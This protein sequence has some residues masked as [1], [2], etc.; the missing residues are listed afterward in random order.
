MEK[1]H[2][3]WIENWVCFWTSGRR[4]LGNVYR[5]RYYCRILWILYLLVIIKRHKWNFF[6]SLS[7]SSAVYSNSERGHWKIII[8][9]YILFG[10][11]ITCSD[12]SHYSWPD[13][14]LVSDIYQLHRSNNK[15]IYHFFKDNSA[16]VYIRH[17]LVFEFSSI[18]SKL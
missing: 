16:S 18:D 7:V 14:P 10:W 4:T 3:I 1:L 9:Y 2:I 5:V 8:Y 11:C 13:N 6:D 15:C 17:W 12:W